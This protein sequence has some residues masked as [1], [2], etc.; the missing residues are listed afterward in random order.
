MKHTT[1][2]EIILHGVDRLWGARVAY[3]TKESDIGE[4]AETQAHLDVRGEDGTWMRVANPQWGGV[5]TQ[6]EA[7][8]RAIRDEIARQ[9]GRTH[10]IGC[11]GHL[12]G[13]MRSTEDGH[14]ID[15][16]AVK[17]WRVRRNPLG[18]IECEALENEHW[19]PVGHPFGESGAQAKRWLHLK[20]IS[21]SR[22]HTQGWDA[23]SIADAAKVEIEDA[24]ATRRPR[25][26]DATVERVG[27]IRT[28]PATYELQALHSDGVVRPAWEGPDGHGVSHTSAGEAVACARD[29]AKA[30]GAARGQGEVP[31]DVSGE[32]PPGSG[33]CPGLEDLD[34]LEG[35]T[36]G[37]RN[38]R[39][40][41]IEVAHDTHTGAVRYHI[42]SMDEEGRER[43]RSVPAPTPEPQAAESAARRIAETLWA[44]H[45]LGDAGRPNVHS[46]SS[47]T[48][49]A[50]GAGPAQAPPRV[51]PQSTQVFADDE[52]FPI[53]ASRTRGPNGEIAP[54][55]VVLDA[56]AGVRPAHLLSEPCVE[57]GPKG[58]WHVWVKDAHG[59]GRHALEG[60][61]CTDVQR[62][63]EIG[64]RAR[65]NLEMAREAH[66]AMQR[67]RAAESARRAPLRRLAGVV[68][69]AGIVAAT[70]A[71]I[72]VTAGA[73]IPI[74]AALGGA[75]TLASAGGLW[76]RRLAREAQAK[77]A[78]IAKRWREGGHFDATRTE[79]A[80]A[81]RATP[82][83]KEAPEQRGASPA[84]AFTPEE[85]WASILAARAARHSNVTEQAKQFEP[86]PKTEPGQTTGPKAPRRTES[87]HERD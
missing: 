17:Q 56:H 86:E 50:P 11:V 59:G 87:T 77:D 2:E 51:L 53:S 75:L 18:E 34:I 48:P 67:E 81:A 52:R 72:A 83:N 54:H 38:E 68:A 63:T 10:A 44:R 9:T 14:P 13:T 20:A 16:S 84:Q 76:G 66:R 39:V 21:A 15:A 47:E 71:G 70:A 65:E 29:V 27:V 64:A 69:G 25:A 73:A 22:G 43:Q 33:H 74:G 19:H 61:A 37:A 23:A 35:R 49:Q 80:H 31:V 8:A 45:G 60:S 28:G 78:E 57:E 46:T 12:P 58:T 41:D 6:V 32:W 85:D 79:R 26:S 62:A 40:L 1:I 55:C 3:E 7:G 24:D 36:G 30:A 42:Q 82:F 5:P 4:E